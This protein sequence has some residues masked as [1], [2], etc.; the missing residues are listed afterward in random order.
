MRERASAGLIR[1]RF[2]FEREPEI[3]D[4]VLL[5]FCTERYIPTADAQA[6][7]AA[8]GTNVTAR[9]LAN[10]VRCAREVTRRTPSTVILE[11]R[12]E[13]I[14]DR[15]ESLSEVEFS[16]SKQSVTQV[17]SLLTL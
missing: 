15:C 13:T 8:A 4:D 7:M 14:F 6:A 2:A 3:F 5:R 11:A 9:R 1:H 17:S 10:C 12:R 16:T